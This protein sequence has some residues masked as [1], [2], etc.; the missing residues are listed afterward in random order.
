MGQSI[1]FWVEENA[2]RKTL[3]SKYQH[4][5]EGASTNKSS[6][7]ATDFHKKAD[8]NTL[9]RPV[10]NKI[11]EISKQ[12]QANP[13]SLDFDNYSNV[14]NYVRVLHSTD[15]TLFMWTGNSL[16]HIGADFL[17]YK[18]LQTILEL[19]KF[20]KNN[21]FLFANDRKLY[22]RIVSGQFKWDNKSAISGDYGIYWIY[23]DY[24]RN[25]SVKNDNMVGE[26]F[27]NLMLSNWDS[28]K[29]IL[30][31]GNALNKVCS[32][33][34]PQFGFFIWGQN[35]LRKLNDIDTEKLLKN[36]KDFE[37]E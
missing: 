21:C 23:E 11:I 13:F 5:I 22:Q 32:V 8:I 15:E 29:S 2:I 20:S 24:T 18:N 14:F 10:G 30:S 7:P 25:H 33:I 9:F 4:I 6:N 1:I 16:V 36:S 35:C 12:Y 19:D 3:Q 17:S 26:Q 28:S 27:L 34:K 37:N 31:H